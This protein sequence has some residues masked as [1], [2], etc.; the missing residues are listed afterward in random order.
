[1]AKKKRAQQNPLSDRGL[2]Q[3]DEELAVIVGSGAQTRNEITSKI[4]AYI[5]DHGLQDKRNK[6]MINADEKLRSI[7]D[8]DSQVSMFEMTKLVDSHIASAKSGAKPP[9]RWSVEELEAAVQVYVEMLRKEADKEAFTKKKYYYE[10]S[11]KFGRTQKAYE[12]WMQNISYVYSLMGRRW[13][14]GL[15]PA[16][17]VGVV[18]TEQLE[19]LINK[20]EGQP[21]ESRAAFYSEVKLHQKKKTKTPPRGNKK[22]QTKTTQVSQYSRDPAVVAWVTNEAAGMCENCKIGAPFVRAD[23][24][25]FLEVHHLRTLADG[26]SD[27]VSNAVAL[28]PNC[29]RAF[30]Y[31]KE[32]SEMLESVY[33][34]VARLIPE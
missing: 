13:L 24:S 32:K 4:W 25:P 31:S 18:V 17:H 3:P 34:K 10:L 6:R 8:G 21:P 26:G 1:M 30:H 22:P 23:D 12:Y 15:K 28:C 27:T 9:K 7:F 14:T 29:H 19:R 16:A 5:A 33:T 2:L 11:K 20:A